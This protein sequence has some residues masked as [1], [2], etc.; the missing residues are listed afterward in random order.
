MV[1]AMN[2]L[3]D[4]FCLTRLGVSLLISSIALSL[5]GQ[6]EKSITSTGPNTSDT[7][8]LRWEF[9]VGR[10][11]PYDIIQG[12]GQLASGTL[13][14]IKE[15]GESGYQIVI[16]ET[17]IPLKPRRFVSKVYHSD[18]YSILVLAIDSWKDNSPGTWYD[19]LV[20]IRD[21]SL[22]GGLPEIRRAMSDVSLEAIDGRRRWVED[23]KEF[24]N[25]PNLLLYM[26]TA[27]KPTPPTRILRAWEVW[28][29]V[30]E[31]M[32][33]ITN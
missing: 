31:E 20:I 9:Q 7:T 13:V 8:I 3:I 5:Y 14:H 33:E 15:N 18:D 23:V 28:D 16:N 22:A 21:S 30:E 6:I 27:E 24:E 10:P 17:S 25:Y 11:S 29:V 4:I 1:E 32:I 2:N 26:A 12:T 19:S